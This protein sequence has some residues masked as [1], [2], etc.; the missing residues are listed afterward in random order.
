[1]QGK[2]FQNRTHLLYCSVLSLGGNVNTRRMSKPDIG[3][4]FHIKKSM[5]YSGHRK[6]LCELSKLSKFNARILSKQWCIYSCLHIPPKENWFQ[7][8]RRVYTTAINFPC[9]IPLEII[10]YSYLSIL[11]QKGVMKTNLRLKFKVYL[12]ACQVVFED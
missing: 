1:M 9:I 11:W 2:L 3:S 5:K 4:I 7:C 8:V 12:Y 6:L 10:I